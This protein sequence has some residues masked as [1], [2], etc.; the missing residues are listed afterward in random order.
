MAK[1]PKK[2]ADLLIEGLYAIKELENKPLGVIRDELGYALD[3]KGGSCVQHW[4]KGKNI[5]S[6]HH[7][8]ITLA[9][10]IKR[11]GQM[12]QEWLESF[13]ASAD[14][15]Y[16]TPSVASESILESKDKVVI[17]REDWIYAY[18]AEYSGIVWTK[19]I[20]KPENSQEKH[21]LSIEWGPWFY[22]CILTFDTEAYAYLV[23]GKS[24]NKMAIPIIFKVS[25]PCNVTFGRGDNNDEHCLDIN[26]GWEWKVL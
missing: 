6:H 14:C 17:Y 24:D 13:F 1:S 19:V 18:P 4:Q 12:N 5:P 3:R 9:L 23:Y 20:A 25:P 2:F 22:S 7:D 11:R 26:R 16:L 21:K 10:E 15:S 8:T